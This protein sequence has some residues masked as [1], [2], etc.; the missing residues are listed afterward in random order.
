MARDHFTFNRENPVTA[1]R[2]KR[3]PPSK[4]RGD[5]AGHGQSMLASFSAAKQ[6]AKTQDQGFDGRLLF[7]IEISDFEGANLEAIPGVELISQEDKGVFLVFSSEQAL[8]EFEA[9]LT[10]LAEGGTPTRKSIFEALDGFDA[11][12]AEDRTGWALGYYGA[13][14]A[15]QFNVDVELWPLGKAADR[16][17]LV[18]AFEEWLPENGITKKDRVFNQSIVLYRL[19]VN[20]RQLEQLLNHRDVRL[21]DLPPKF[22]LD[23]S[24][25]QRDIQDIPV[26]PAPADDAPAVVVLDSGLATGH[27]LL[28]S[29]VGD[30]QSFI[31]GKGSDDENGHGTMVAGKA[32]YGDVAAKLE[33]GQFIPELRLFSGRI[34]DENCESDD[35]LIEHQ[36]EKAVRYFVENYTCKIFNLSYGDSNKPYSGGRIRGLAVVLDTL[37]SELGVLFVVPTGNYRSDDSPTAW[38]ESYPDSLVDRRLL[39]PAP[40]I[41]SITVG[42]L[43]RYD[44]T[45]SSMRHPSDPAEQ[46][47]AA[48]NQP[49]PFSRSGPGI[50][51][52]IKPEFVAYGGN[53]A[54]NTRVDSLI[55]NLLGEVSLCKDFT[56]G[57]LVAE[58]VGTSFSAPFIAHLAARIL[59]VYPDATL[60]QVRALLASHA[61][62][63]TEVV[64][65]FGKGKDKALFTTG[66]GVVDEEALFRSLDDD[67]S[68]FAQDSLRN[69]SHH[70]YEIPIPNEFWAGS[71]RLR[72][73]AVS[74][75]HTPQVRTTRVDYKTT[76]MSF[77][78]IRAASLDEV[79]KRFN[80]AV[81]IE[82]TNK[83]EEYKNKRQVTEM[84][85]NHGTL[86]CSTWNFKQVSARERLKKFFVVVTRHD[87]PWAESFLPDLE[88]Y[89]LVVNLRD[90]ENERAELLQ[91]V[92]AILQSRVRAQ[93]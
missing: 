8:E 72:Q 47:F 19:E 75:A 89:S 74:L 62:M 28:S 40:S 12:T 83:F 78:L 69:K 7:K 6:S 51:K 26:V 3:P 37:A 61:S 9:R 27:P 93:V 84:W 85:R 92:E 46:S 36:V 67:L 31:D 90:K 48:I 13:P 65:L 23:V 4:P 79:S 81:P 60:D 32:L 22:R 44:Q 16:E 50:K 1:K 29:A 10:T 55:H 39:D 91:Q 56:A 68:I 59:V 17:A 21:V 14:E 73:I 30:S 33:S 70:F 25:L 86:Q 20:T 41:N 11:F 53:Y 2:P 76:R 77:K 45:M 43:A 66:Y 18:N 5:L 58:D 24:L 34:L 52:S 15:N 35:K 49:S 82:E 88:S 64:N 87:Y 38:K 57:R 42:S 71:K 54:V 63:P 80:H